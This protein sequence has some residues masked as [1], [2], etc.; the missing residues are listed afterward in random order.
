MKKKNKKTR[1][2]QM[3]FKYIFIIFFSAIL[4]PSNYYAKSDNPQTLTHFV[5]DQN[6]LLDKLIV[7][8]TNDPKE[9]DNQQNVTKIPVYLVLFAIS[10]LMVS[11]LLLTLILRYFKNICIAKRSIFVA[12]YEDILK[13]ILCLEWC[14][15]A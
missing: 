9:N 10:A 7:P 1:C 2:K 12:L 13:I 14:Y 6:D 4:F 3:R 11:T 8:S 15:V 5:S